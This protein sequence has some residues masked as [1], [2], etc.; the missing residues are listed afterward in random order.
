MKESDPEFLLTFLPPDSGSQLLWVFKGCIFP[1]TSSVFLRGIVTGL[2][3][4]PWSSRLTIFQA[5]VW[6]SEVFLHFLPIVKC[7]AMETHGHTAQKSLT[8]S[9]PQKN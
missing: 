6:T 1:Q 9:T 2:A 8:N 7:L 4:F 3:S 5:I